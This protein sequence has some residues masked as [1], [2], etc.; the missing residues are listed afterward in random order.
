MNTCSSSIFSFGE[1][2]SA[3][4]DVRICISSLIGI[5][6]MLQYIQRHHCVVRLIYYDVYIQGEGGYNS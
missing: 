1:T 2:K 4:A 5:Y 3:E 6:I